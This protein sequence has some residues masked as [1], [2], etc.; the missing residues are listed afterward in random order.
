MTCEKTVC[1]PGGLRRGRHVEEHGVGHRTPYEFEAVEPVADPDS[2]TPPTVARKPGEAGYYLVR[3]GEG[4]GVLD[5][6]TGKTAAEGAFE[7]PPSR[8]GH[9]PRRA[10]HRFR[11]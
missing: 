8:C 1:R 11:L 4:W 6:R 5:V 2:T 9:F 10:A 7:E 3:T